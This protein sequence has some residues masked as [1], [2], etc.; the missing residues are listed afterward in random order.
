MTWI[1][2]AGYEHRED[3]ERVFGELLELGVTSEDLS[4][5][6]K[7]NGSHSA[8]A[9]NARRMVD[10][11][12]V[13]LEDNA[14]TERGLDESDRESPIGGGIATSCS[15]D[16]VSGPEEMDDGS[17]AAEDMTDPAHHRSY[18]S[19][20]IEDA[21]T[22]AALGSVDASRPVTPGFNRS[23]SQAGR[24]SER[25]FSVEVVGQA[26]IIGDGPLATETLADELREPESALPHVVEGTLRRTGVDPDEAAA[27][28]RYLNNGG[29]IIAVTETVG[30][31]SFEQIEAYIEA[32]GG[33]H[34]HSFSQ[35]EA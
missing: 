19:E 15:D 6:M 16:N 8:E 1:L 13:G 29:A 24:S 20:D 35:P 3:A 18:G 25:P 28:S 9:E 2:Y 30:I 5:V 4:L 27:L 26:V 7:A 31:V 21:E 23:L 32:S 12:Q 10:S 17:L 11:G 33:A 34:M 14:V 22:F